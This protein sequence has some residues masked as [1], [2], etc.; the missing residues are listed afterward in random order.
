MIVLRVCNDHFAPEYSDNV[1]VGLNWIVIVLNL[2]ICLLYNISRKHAKGPAQKYQNE[3]EPVPMLV[4][5]LV[6]LGTGIF[7]VDGTYG[8]LLG[9]GW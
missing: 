1:V 3:D 2:S 6:H 8:W 7:W 5:V 4:L 9:T